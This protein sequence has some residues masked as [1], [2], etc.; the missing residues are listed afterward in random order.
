M[1]SRDGAIRDGAIRDG[2]IRDCDRNS[3]YPKSR[4]FGIVPFGI[5]TG[6]VSMRNH[7]IWYRVK[8]RFDA[9]DVSGKSYAKFVAAH[10]LLYHLE[11]KNVSASLVKATMSISVRL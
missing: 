7:A 6:I 5:V 11:T 10:K 8:D 9:C 4:P 2:A 1:P 3:I